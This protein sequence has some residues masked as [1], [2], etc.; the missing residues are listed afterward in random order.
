LKVIFVEPIHV[1]NSK[2][3]RN[4][5][6]EANNYRNPDNFIDQEFEYPKVKLLKEVMDTTKSKMVLYTQARCCSQKI[7][8]LIYKLNKYGLPDNYWLD[9]VPADGDQYQALLKWMASNIYRNIQKY[10]ILDS[11]GTGATSDRDP[12]VIWA[13]EE[14]LTEA[15]AQE[16]IEKLS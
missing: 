8:S 9:T 12:N 14:G 4:Q 1:L 13:R 16:L 15:L 10:V 11:L 2:F 3:Y 5:L 6:L 7:G